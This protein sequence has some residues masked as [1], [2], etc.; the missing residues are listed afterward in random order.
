MILNKTRN[1]IFLNGAKF[2]R[3]WSE[4]ICMGVS[5]ITIDQLFKVL[6]PE[7]NQHLKKAA[8]HKAD[9]KWTGFWQITLYVHQVKPKILNNIGI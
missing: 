2:S 8:Q 6:H 1:L 5:F 9:T 7:Y 3:F 4:P